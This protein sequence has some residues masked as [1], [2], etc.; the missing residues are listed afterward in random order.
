ME[1]V[2]AESQSQPSD[3][4]DRLALVPV[5][6]PP[7][8]KP[9]SVSN[10]RSGL[11]GRLQDRQQEIEVSCASAHDAHPEGAEIEMATETSTVPVVV[12]DEDA[13]GK[14]HPAENAEATHPE[15]K[16]PSVA[17]SGEEPVN[18]AACSSASSFSYAELEDKLKQIPPGSP[19]IMPSA[20]MFENVEMVKLFFVLFDCFII[21]L[22]CCGMICNFALLVCVSAGE[23]SPRHGPTTRSLF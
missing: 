4:P 13:P 12:L 20:Q 23:W 7:S 6:G 2:G 16:S 3:D 19:D 9:R 15:R 1:E 8:K 17:S 18:D 5:K 11:L 22:C 14:T 10:L 21:L